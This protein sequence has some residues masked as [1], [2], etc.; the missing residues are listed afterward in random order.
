MVQGVV[1]GETEIF[2][3][4]RV[5]FFTRDLPALFNFHFDGKGRVEGVTLY[6][7]GKTL[8]GKRLS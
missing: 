4:S 5:Q 1:Y 7:R 6:L 3:F 8:H 2:P